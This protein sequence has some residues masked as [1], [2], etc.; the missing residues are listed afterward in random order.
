M[1]RAA[2]LLRWLGAGG[3]ITLALA[4]APGLLAQV[5]APG[6]LPKDSLR[7][8]PHVYWESSSKAIVFYQ[9]GDTLAG[10]PL[11]VRGA[12]VF[13]GLCGDEDT[14]YLISARA[15]EIEPD[16]FDGIPRILAGDAADRLGLAM[17]FTGVRHFRH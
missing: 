8:G 11:G 6:P 4:M 15:P 10:Q 5:T 17:V 14:E 1:M 13:K 7:D 2:S 9:C 3:A 12:G 16:Q